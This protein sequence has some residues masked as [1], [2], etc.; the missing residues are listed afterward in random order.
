MGTVCGLS[1]LLA[2]LSACAHLPQKNGPTA[3]R[4][5]RKDGRYGTV[6]FIGN[7]PFCPQIRNWLSELLRWIPAPSEWLIGQSI[8]QSI[9]ACWVCGQLSAHIFSSWHYRGAVWWTY[10]GVSGRRLPTQC[11]GMRKA[12]SC[13]P[14]LWELHPEEPALSFS[15]GWLIG[16]SEST[17]NGVTRSK[18]Q[19]SHM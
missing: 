17:L 19:F 15:L 8:N 2:K 1:Y 6:Y 13:G 12:Q 10:E 16:A 9:K 14:E 7:Y 4:H 11:L 5:I 18:V 3:P